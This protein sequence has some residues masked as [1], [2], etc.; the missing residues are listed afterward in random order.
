MLAPGKESYDKPRPFIKKQRHHFANKG[1]SVRSYGFSSSH[2]WMDVRW[3]IKKAECGKID[4]FE[5]WCW[6]RLLRVPWTASRSNQSLLKKTNLEYLLE[7]LMLELKLQ[8]FGHLLQRANS[9]EKTLMLGK[10]GGDR[11]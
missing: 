9:L 6:R 5:L 2:G 4:G 1:P 8:S 10:T 7:R 3:T 11:G